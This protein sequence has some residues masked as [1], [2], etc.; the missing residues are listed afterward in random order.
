MCNAILFDDIYGLDYRESLDVSA[1]YFAVTP[2]DV[3]KL[4]QKI[5]SG[6]SVISIVGPRD[7]E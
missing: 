6:P 4:A 2:E 5:F 1:K 7:A 3:Q